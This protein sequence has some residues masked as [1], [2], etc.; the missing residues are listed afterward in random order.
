MYHNPE[1]EPTLTEKIEQM[2]RLLSS[3]PTRTEQEKQMKRT[4]ERE[5]HR[6]IFFLSSSKGPFLMWEKWSLHA[7]V[8]DG[9]FDPLH[10][11]S[12][13]WFTLS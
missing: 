10:R 12:Y 8:Y 13:Q 1:F 9:L 2:E 4:V 7:V 11:V 3:T 6:L 5:C